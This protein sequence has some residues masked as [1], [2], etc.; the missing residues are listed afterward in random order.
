MARIYETTGSR[1]RFLS[2][3]AAG[4][5]AVIVSPALAQQSTLAPTPNE[6]LMHEHG[7]VGRVILIYR[8]AIELLREGVNVDAALIGEPARLVARVIH[9]HHEV[10]EEEIVFP[11]VD[12]TREMNMLVEV[13]RGQHRAARTLTAT[14]GNNA[15]P[16]RLKDPKRRS[17]LIAAMR[18][19]SSMYE[20]HGAFEDTLVYP[21]FRKTA[22]PA[23]Y[24]KLA[25]RFAEN[26]QRMH[27]ETG[28]ERYVAQLA[29]IEDV[30][31]IG[32]ARYT[33]QA[34]GVGRSEKSPAK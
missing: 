7:L 3:A 14:I 11:L 6:D 22:G 30:L 2:L 17:E 32:L 20:P 27:G 23:E 18:D 12:R 8:R 21:A 31:G 1:R 29:R 5:P 26:E 13:L 15:T 10:E 4:V 25:R 24:E 28:F 34:A 33:E 9:G 16:E 19:F